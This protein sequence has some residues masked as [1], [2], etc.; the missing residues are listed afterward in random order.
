MFFSWD[1][2]LHL[3]GQRLVALP[4]LEMTPPSN[5][6]VNKPSPE[7]IDNNT[8][9]HIQKLLRKKFK[10]E[11]KNVWLFRA[12]FDDANAKH[13][14]WVFLVTTAPGHR[15]DGIDIPLLISCFRITR[16]ECI[17]KKPWTCLFWVFV[18][19]IKERWDKN[20]LCCY[21]VWSGVSLK[22]SQPKSTNAF[23]ISIMI[24]AHYI[25]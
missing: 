2:F 1:S 25:K 22:D 8:V 7:F 17:W 13:L 11:T 15:G 5:V 18:S 12:P 16:F 24:H 14:K 19:C 3:F 9:L 21:F 20:M 10:T 6:R 23:L 4:L